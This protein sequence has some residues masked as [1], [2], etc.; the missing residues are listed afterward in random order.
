MARHKAGLYVLFAPGLSPEE[1][2][3]SVS[4]SVQISLDARTIAQS[5]DVFL[6]R[7]SAVPCLAKRVAELFPSA[8]TVRARIVKEGLIESANSATMPIP[9]G[10][11]IRF[12]VV[13][14]DQREM[15]EGDALLQVVLA[16]VSASSYLALAGTPF[17]MRVRAASTL[18]EVRGA[19]LEA[20]AVDEERAKKTKF[21][22]GRDWVPYSPAGVVKDGDR[23][24]TV[25]ND[26][27][28]VVV[29]AKRPIGAQQKLE[30]ALWIDK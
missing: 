11:T 3:N 28:H 4:V 15:P 16:T 21:F 19:V 14:E 7:G 26:V 17:F 12:E 29:D 30:E 20:L 22:L 25:K 18:G 24:V 1:H 5:L 13:P 10:T 2:E 8:N 9:D 6:P 27:L 23:V